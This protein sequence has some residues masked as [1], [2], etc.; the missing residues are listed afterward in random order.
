[1]LTA[2]RETFTYLTFFG[3]PKDK[4]IKKKKKSFPPC[5]IAPWG[6]C[7]SEKWQSMTCNIRMY[8]LSLYSGLTAMILYTIFW[9]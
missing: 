7:I 8:T 5:W 2:S 6:T 9:D 3:L 1:M 4:A